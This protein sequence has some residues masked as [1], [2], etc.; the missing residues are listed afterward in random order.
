[1]LRVLLDL[2]GEFII[3]KA[4]PHHRVRAP[5]YE[6]DGRESRTYKQFLPNTS[7]M[8]YLSGMLYNHGFVLAVGARRDHK[9]RY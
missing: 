2:D 9:C 3:V 8:D 4:D 6:K 1:M 5:R 7:R